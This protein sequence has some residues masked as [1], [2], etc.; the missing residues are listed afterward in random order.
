[1]NEFDLTMK[2]ALD[3]VRLA[4]HNKRPTTRDYIDAMIDDFIEL[5]G[6]RRFADDPAMLAGIGFLEGIPVTILGQQKGKNVKENIRRNFGMAHPEGY[7]K[8]LRLMQQAERFGRPVITLIDTPGAYPGIGA[9]ERG[10]AE[11]IAVNL[12]EMS[13]LRVPIVACVTGEGGSGGALGIAVADRVFMLSNA[14]YSVISPE[15]CASILWKDTGRTAEAAEALRL[16]A[17]DLKDLKV[18]DGIIPEPDPGAHEFPAETTRR[19]KKTLLQSLRALLSLDPETLVQQ[20]YA[21]FR[22]MGVY[23]TTGPTI[24]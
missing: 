24:F 9:E 11:A 7:R 16:T 14:I 10:Q 5:H 12:Y 1:M 18:I 22:N 21:K 8:A 4:R 3:T 13:G 19:L 6:D 17:R 20:R 15:G 23:T 2:T